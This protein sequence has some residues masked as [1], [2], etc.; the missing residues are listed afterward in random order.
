MRCVRFAPLML[1][2]WLGGCG[3]FGGGSN[4]GTPLIADSRSP[5]SDVPV[6]AGF[7][8]DEN[9]SSKLITGSA[10]RLVD[11]RYKGGDD[12]MPVVSFYK[13]Q[14]PEREWTFVDLSQ[15][16]GKEISLHFS[17]RNEDCNVTV[18]RRTF[19]TQ[20]RIKIDPKSAK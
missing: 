9:S 12:L 20:I 1:V 8:M 10:L 16:S 15:I 17:K 7:T 4:A 18:T 14:M 3:L 19:D 5:I 13:A 2:V 11:H 6:P